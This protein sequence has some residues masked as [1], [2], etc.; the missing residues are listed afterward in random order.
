[1]TSK[2]RNSVA[3]PGMKRKCTFIFFTCLS[4]SYLTPLSSSERQWMSRCH[5]SA[6]QKTW[7]LLNL[8]K[9]RTKTRWILSLLIKVNLQLSNNRTAFS[10]KILSKYS[11]KSIA[12]REHLISSIG[13]YSY[14]IER[15]TL[16]I[17]FVSSSQASHLFKIW[18]TLLK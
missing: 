3:R 12:Y 1:M 4:L 7:L 17:S 18:T 16:A 2:L 10:Q 6:Y 15:K 8:S 13:D 9:N 5:K 11:S 14:L